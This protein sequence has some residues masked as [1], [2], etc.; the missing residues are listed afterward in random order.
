[1]RAATRCR[2]ERG[3]AVPIMLGL[4]AVAVVVLLALVPLARAAQQ[5]AAAR[6]AADAAALAGAAEGVDAAREVAAENGA[7]L[8]GWRAQGRDVWVVVTLGDARADA[9]ARRDR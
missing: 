6:N 4:V 1:M 9:K 3:Q 7:E 8:I 5:R 2:D